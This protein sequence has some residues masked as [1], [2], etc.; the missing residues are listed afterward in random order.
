M[1]PYKKKMIEGKLGQKNER[2]A[3]TERPGPYLVS[4]KI[5]LTMDIMGQ[6]ADENMQKSPAASFVSDLMKL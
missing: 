6:A 4:C 2:S 3:K 1:Q 5:S